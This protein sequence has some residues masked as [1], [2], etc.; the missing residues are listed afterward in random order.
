MLT[1]GEFLK[2]F[3][4]AILNYNNYKA[5][6]RCIS[7]I[8]TSDINYEYEIAILDNG[9]SNDSYDILNNYYD[10]YNNINV[11]KNNINV[12]FGGGKKKI[13]F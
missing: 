12:G 10:G 5:T 6:E 3:G 2:V 11:I 7:S 13:I 8:L 1:K 4:I 9:S